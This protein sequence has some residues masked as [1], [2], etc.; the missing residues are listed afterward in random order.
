VAQFIT[1]KT[2]E[3]QSHH[4][5]RYECRAEKVART[6]AGSNFAIMFVVQVGSS[7]INVGSD[8][9]GVFELIPVNGRLYR[10]RDRRN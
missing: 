1:P 5:G 9:M 2:S 10:E 6:G 3:N 7:C 8:E 4:H